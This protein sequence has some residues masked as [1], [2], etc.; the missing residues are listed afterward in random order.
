M[1]IAREIKTVLWSLIGV[2]RRSRLEAPSDHPLVLIAV[3]FVLVLVFLGT[4]A[5]IALQAP[6]ALS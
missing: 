5:F 2:A 1:N 4:L 3:A 6:G